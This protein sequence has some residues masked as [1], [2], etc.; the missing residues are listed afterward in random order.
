MLII[1]AIA[2]IL[3][4]TI[5]V[6]KEKITQPEVVLVIDSS[7]SMRAGTEAST[8]YERAVEAAVRQ[9]GETFDRDGIVSVILAETITGFWWREPMRTAGTESS[10]I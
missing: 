8:R 3:A 7:A 5:H 4:K 6:L 10:E 1:T 2:A 9:A